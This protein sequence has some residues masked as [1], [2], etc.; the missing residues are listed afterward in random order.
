MLN[1]EIDMLRVGDEF[2]NARGGRAVCYAKRLHEVTRRIV[3]QCM[4][5]DS[6]ATAQPFWLNTDSPVQVTGHYPFVAA[7]CCRAV[8]AEFR[9]SER[10]ARLDRNRSLNARH[11]E[12]WER[13][14]N[15]LDALVD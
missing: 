2:R 5:V 11:A 1:R 3:C 7:N 9:A 15:R 12:R 10:R 8:A 4:H 13:Y 6:G 14:A